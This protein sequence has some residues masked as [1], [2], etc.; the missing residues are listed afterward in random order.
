MLQLE[1][2]YAIQWTVE[3]EY[4]GSLEDIGETA[5]VI[6]YQLGNCFGSNKHK[7]YHETIGF[8]TSY[9]SWMAVLYFG[10]VM[11]AVE[12]CDTDAVTPLE[13][14]NMFRL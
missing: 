7:I 2:E 4:I 14:G 3:T 11:D 6:Q 10:Y 5:L 9:V 12:F 1:T 13:R 8:E